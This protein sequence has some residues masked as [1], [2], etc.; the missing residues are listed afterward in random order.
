M[1]GIPPSIRDG[2]DLTF[3]TFLVPDPPPL[4]GRGARDDRRRVGEAAAGEVEEAAGEAA[5]A[6]GDGAR[7]RSRSLSSAPP[8]YRR[9]RT[10]R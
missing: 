8:P 5:K 9:R 1:V 6:A 2:G 4:H 10:R 7:R 3:S